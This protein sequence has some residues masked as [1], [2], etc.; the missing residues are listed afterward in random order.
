MWS[1]IAHPLQQETKTKTKKQNFCQW[2]TEIISE[3][4]NA[5]A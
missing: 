2:S 1:W 3:Q 5:T 4:K